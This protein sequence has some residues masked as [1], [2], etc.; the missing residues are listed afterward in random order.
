[1]VGHRAN[2]IRAAR[3]GQARIRAGVVAT[4]FTGAAVPVVVACKDAAVVEANVSEEAVV[5]DAAGHWNENEKRTH[6]K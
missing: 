2:G 1:M 4:R 3:A 6:Y 5:V